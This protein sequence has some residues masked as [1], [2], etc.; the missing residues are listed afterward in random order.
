MKTN[1]C[2]TVDTEALLEIKKTS[3]NLSKI[4]SDYLVEYT[5]VETGSEEFEVPEDKKKFLQLQQIKITKEL[6]QITQDDK[7]KKQALL[8]KY[9]NQKY[10]CDKVNKMV[11]AEQYKF[12]TG[13]YP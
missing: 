12:L 10:W 3:V 2:V 1:I 13:E 8:S 5:G 7:K 11:G 6:E 9:G 4:L